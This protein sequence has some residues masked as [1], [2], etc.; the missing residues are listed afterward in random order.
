MV[1]PIIVLLGIP[2]LLGI[3]YIPPFELSKEVQ[4]EVISEEPDLSFLYYILL[5]IWTLYLIK[6]LF[7]VKKGTFKIT[8]RY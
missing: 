4:E 5:G 3:V 1:I 8:Q 6:I 2:I 7:Q